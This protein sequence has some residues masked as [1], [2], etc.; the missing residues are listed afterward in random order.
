[1]AEAREYERCCKMVFDILER[2][3][4]MDAMLRELSSGFGIPVIVTDPCGKR[5]IDS[6]TEQ[7]CE[8]AKK[9][10]INDRFWI[11]IV[12]EF[13][14]SEEEEAYIKGRIWEKVVRR[15]MI[16]AEPFFVKGI[17]GGFCI[18][19]HEKRKNARSMNQLL[20]RA[21]SIGMG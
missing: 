12:E 4:Q 20:T 10:E 3:D 11:G 17:M 16:V 8:L 14:D 6:G 1:M 7:F 2:N 15:G 9:L 21:V 19:Y 5:L 13:Y 18:T